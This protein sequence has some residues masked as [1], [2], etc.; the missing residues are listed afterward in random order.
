MLNGYFDDLFNKLAIEHNVKET[1]FRHQFNEVHKI[2]PK[3]SPYQSI[4]NESDRLS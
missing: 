1:S 4:F 3:G 2:N